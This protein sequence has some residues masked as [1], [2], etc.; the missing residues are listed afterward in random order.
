MAKTLND[1]KKEKQNLEN[2]ISSR[3]A[4]NKQI[5][6][7]INRLQ[8]AYNKLADIKRNN[9]NNAEKVKNNTKLVKV[10]DKVEWRGQ[11]KDRF[12]NAM[13]DI[14]TPAA[15]A[16]YDS[17]DAIHDE[18]GKA[19]SNKRGEYNTGSS[20]LNSLNKSWNNVTGIIRNWVN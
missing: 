7:E 18:I 19:L 4:K 5:S 6:G 2:Q 3:K 12:D 8:T 13:K 17:I 15:K 20:I 10:A 1:Y 16:F 14:A 9:Y 11:Y